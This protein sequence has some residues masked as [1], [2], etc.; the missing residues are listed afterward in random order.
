MSEF[1]FGLNIFIH[2]IRSHG[3]LDARTD[4]ITSVKHTP[5]L[6]DQDSPIL[7]LDV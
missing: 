3:Q 1:S 5:V 7:R 4:L 2:D 6:E